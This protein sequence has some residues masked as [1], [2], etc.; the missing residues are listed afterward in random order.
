MTMS[1]TSSAVPLV[2]SST[3]KRMHTVAFRSDSWWTLSDSAA[4]VAVV[5][6]CRLR[7]IGSP[8]Q[9][10][11]NLTEIGNW[12]LL[13]WELGIGNSQLGMEWNATNPSALAAAFG[14]KCGWGVASAAPVPT[15]PVPLAAARMQI[16]HLGSRGRRAKVHLR[17][18]LT[19]L[20]TAG[21]S[22][23]GA[24]KSNSRF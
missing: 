21:A 11:L 10:P 6:P 7:A 15:P 24:L 8:W 5:I 14:A 1:D 9:G 23:D 16:A 22:W 12:E 2:F 19:V 20:T 17:H 3:G 4:A 18:E 13:N